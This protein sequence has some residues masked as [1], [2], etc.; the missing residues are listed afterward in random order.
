MKAALT[1]TMMI[2]ALTLASPSFAQDKA[3]KSE[4]CRSLLR[5]V[6]NAIPEHKASPGINMKEVNRQRDRGKDYCNRGMYTEGTKALSIALSM[7]NVKPAK[8]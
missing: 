5:Q 3:A 6:D 2:L 4:R 8:N 7:M 1:A